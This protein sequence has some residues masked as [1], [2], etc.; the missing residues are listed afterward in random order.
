MIVRESKIER[1]LETE[2]S[3]LGGT[4]RKLAYQG[5]KGAP[6][7][8]VLLPGRM[9]MVELKAPGKTARIEQEREHALLRRS[10]ISVKTLDTIEAVDRWVQMVQETN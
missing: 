3:R 7:R 5:R 10:G 2:V 4:T 8:L 6:D 1:H 9:F